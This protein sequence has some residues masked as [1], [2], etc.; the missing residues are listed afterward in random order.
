MK[1][2]ISEIWQILNK[3]TRGKMAVY[4]LACCMYGL[5]K[6]TILDIADKIH[7]DLY[8]DKWNWRKRAKIR[9]QNEKLDKCRI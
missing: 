8:L 9:I 2:T 7:N 3:A 5:D 4:D 6:N 1:P